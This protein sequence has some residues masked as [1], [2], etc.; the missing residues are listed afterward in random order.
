MRRD[1]G[2]SGVRAVASGRRLREPSAREFQEIA[3]LIQDAAGIA[4]N[5]SKRAL[6][7][8]RLANRVTALGLSSFDEYTTLVRADDSGSELVQ[9]LDLIATNETHFFREPAHFDFLEQRVYPH[10]SEQAGTGARSRG[11]RVWS[12]ACSTGQEPYSLAMHLLSHFPALDGWSIE[13]LATDISTR[14]LATAAS[15]VWSLD[16]AHEIPPHFL[17]RYMR[18]GVGEQLGRMRASDELRRVVRFARV[19]LAADH[20][21]VP[22][23]FDLIFCRNVLIYFTP[24]G[25]AAVIENLTK[26][27]A[28]GGLLFV[29]HAESL[30][31]HRTQLHP[32]MPTV[33]TRAS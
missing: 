7:V 1:T 4:L 31:A 6:L 2:A 19:N 3:S 15:G 13:L 10:W 33:Y 17:Q 8:R 25:R 26:R 28:P 24:E 21:P 14:A 22:G 30:H 18:R 5:E 29:G 12:A 16:K 20:Y 11:V 27:L 9:L 32:L 23:S